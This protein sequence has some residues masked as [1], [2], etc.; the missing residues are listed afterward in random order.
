MRVG[1]VH[2]CCPRVPTQLETSGARRNEAFQLTSASRLPSERPRRRRSLGRPQRLSQ[3]TKATPRRMSGSKLLLPTQHQV[4]RNRRHSLIT[5][6]H[7]TTMS[8][9]S[10]TARPEYTTVRSRAAVHLIANAMC[11][12]APPRRCHTHPHPSG[13]RMSPTPRGQALQNTPAPILARLP[14]PI[15]CTSL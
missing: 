2:G 5:T 13:S 10:I 14:A 8:R 12:G 1:Q 11:Y 3:A 6:L 15:L 4:T 7:R 9:H